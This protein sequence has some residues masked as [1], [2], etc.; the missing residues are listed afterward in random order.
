MAILSV[1]DKDTVW[2]PAL[3]KI[4]FSMSS[5]AVVVVL[6]SVQASSF[7]YLIEYCM[8]RIDHTD[9]TFSKSRK[10]SKSLYILY[11]YIYIYIICILY[12]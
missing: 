1:D 12:I 9:L 6:I 5:N 11:I 7:L 8:D 4:S 3:C 10:C 2:A